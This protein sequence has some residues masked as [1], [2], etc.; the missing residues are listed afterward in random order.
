[1]AWRLDG[2]LDTWDVMIFYRLSLMTNAMREN[3]N[4]IISW[5]SQMWMGK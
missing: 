5:R 3:L 4:E 2:F 1:M